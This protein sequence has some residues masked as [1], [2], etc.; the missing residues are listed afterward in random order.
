ML[1][2]TWRTMCFFFIEVAFVSSLLHIN[3]HCQKNK[4][5]LTFF[6]IFGL[7]FIA[8]TAIRIDAQFVG[9]WQFLFE[10]F[11]YGKD[12]L[13]FLN[14]NFSKRAVS[15]FFS[16]SSIVYLLELSCFLEKRGLMS[17]T[18]YRQPFAEPLVFLIDMSILFSRFVEFSDL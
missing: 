18:F 13:H 12:S 16:Y 2:A 14:F 17:G 1:G 4:R 9:G 10:S 11:N 6:R 15:V 3:C 7:I 5:F 8:R